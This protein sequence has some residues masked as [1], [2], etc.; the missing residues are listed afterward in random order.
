MFSFFKFLRKKKVHQSDKEKEKEEQEKETIICTGTGNA[1]DSAVQVSTVQTKAKYIKP[2][3]NPQ[4]R[5]AYY[6]KPMAHKAAIDNAFSGGKTVRD[7]YTGAKLLKKQRD[8]K[9]HYGKDWQNHA[10][11]AD[12]IDPLSQVV[13]RNKDNPFLTKEDIRDI[14]NRKE[15]IQV[16]SRKMNQSSKDVGKGGSTQ[17]EWARDSRRMKGVEK[18][19]QSGETITKV[20]RK[21]AKRGREAEVKN[22]QLALKKSVGNA[23]KI[24]HKAGVQGAVSAGGTALT[25]SSIINI[26]EVIEGKKSPK[27]AVANI[28][29][30]GGKGAVGGYLCSGALTTV[31]QSLSGSSSPFIQALIKSNV[32]GK[33]VTGIMV[34]GHTLKRYANGEI[35]TEECLYELGESSINYVGTGYAMMAGQ[36]LIPI[37]IVG[38]A[39]GALVGSALMS[40]YCSALFGDLQGK[41]MRHQERLQIMEEYKRSA[42]Q[43]RA[44]Q[45]ELQKYLDDYFGE[46]RHCFDEALYT[47]RSSFQIGDADGIIAGSNQIT[48]KLGGKVRYRNMEEFKKY[49]AED[50]TDVL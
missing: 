22:D 28:V 12:H 20:R 24:F 44:F 10:A 42:E 45:A 35:T 8:A 33:V 50:S 48:E 41:E 23:T 19:I 31:Y 16:I 17:E 7:L 36:A 21:I 25:M 6:D 46:Y 26:K 13:K 29:K 40:R 37:P 5:R 9:I 49:L 14:G 11:E 2:E 34:T 39:V 47:I 32:P 38:A 18:N 27:E 4:N 43:S 15:N 30:D 3:Y 1:L